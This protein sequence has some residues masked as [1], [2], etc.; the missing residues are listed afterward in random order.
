[1]WEWHEGLYW[2]MAFGGVWTILFW[3]T[4]MALVAWIVKIVTKRSITKTDTA[5]TI[6]PID[7]IKGYYAKGEITREEFEYLK[8]DLTKP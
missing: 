8:K 5:F 4:I 7:I 6:K 3:A 1:M 2:W